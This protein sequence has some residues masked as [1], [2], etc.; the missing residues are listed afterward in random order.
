MRK[1]KK[2]ITVFIILVV[3]VIIFSAFFGVFKLDKNGKWKNILPNLK[4]GMELDKT[5]VIHADIS[6]AEETIIYDKEGNVEEQEE[7][8]E[9]K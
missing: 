7:G 9:Y 4:L 3:A 8:K 1:Y 6:K 2:T 5:R